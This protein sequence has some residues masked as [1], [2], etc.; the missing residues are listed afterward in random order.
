MSLARA[1]A[2][3]PRLLLADEPTSNLDAES[4]AI[5]CDVLASLSAE[6]CTVIVATH[7][8]TLLDR[9]DR[10]LRMESGRLIEPA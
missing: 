5:V 6:G 8:D 4:A 10:V 1:L 7:D 9:S 3:R 2:H